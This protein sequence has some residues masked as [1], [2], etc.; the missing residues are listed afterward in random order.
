MFPAATTEKDSHLA[1][2]FGVRHEFGELVRQ[3]VPGAPYQGDG[4]RSGLPIPS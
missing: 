3:G 1:G 4:G 2:K